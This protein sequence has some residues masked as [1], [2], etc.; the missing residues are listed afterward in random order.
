MFKIDVE[1]IYYI[2]RC[3]PVIAQ[4][5]LIICKEGIQINKIMRSVFVENVLYFVYIKH[6][7]IFYM[8][9]VSV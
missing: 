6:I 1:V 8:F 7:H 3:M 4:V 9:T 2:C 5:P